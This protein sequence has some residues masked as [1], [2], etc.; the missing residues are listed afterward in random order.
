MPEVVLTDQILAKPFTRGEKVSQ[1]PPAV[2]STACW[3]PARLVDGALIVRKSGILQFYGA[4]PGKC[5]SFSPVTG[6]KHAV[7]H[8]DT[9]SHRPDDVSLVSHAHQISRPILWQQLGGERHGLVNLLGPLPDGNPPDGIPRKIMG[10]DLF[11]APLPERFVGS[12][13]DDSEESLADHSQQ[14]LPPDASPGFR[15]CRPL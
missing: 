4:C 15:S 6:W 3:T 14:R 5:V 7:E 12:A 10:T 1:I 13:L 2:A 11:D 9:R 8:V